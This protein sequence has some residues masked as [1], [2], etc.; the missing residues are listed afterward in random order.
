MR[1]VFLV[2][3]LSLGLAGAAPARQGSGKSLEEL[4]QAARAAQKAGKKDEA[5]RL[6]DQA[7]KAYPKEAGAFALRGLIREE[8]DDLKGSLADFTK[9][10]ELQPDAAQFWD[11]RGAVNFKS[12]HIKESIQ[13]FDKAIELQPDLANGHWMRGISYYYAGRYD[14]GRRQFERYESVDTNDVENAVWRY[15]CMAKA[16]GVEKA[17]AALLKIGKD[18][19]VPMMEVYEL[20][21][22]KLK[23]EDVLKAAEA[24]EAPAALRNRQRFYAHLYLGLF[25]EANGD[26]AKALEHLRRAVEHRINHYMWDVARV[27]R[28]TL[29]KSSAKK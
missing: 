16:I 9:V 3:A 2:V 8:Q 1:R 5:L 14:D 7:V 26:A 29:L 13:D 4:F 22:G 17:R 25:H 15:L 24:G 10:L 21:Q 23:P 19:R 12:G 20:F 11:R 18:K 6:A 28:D 27:G